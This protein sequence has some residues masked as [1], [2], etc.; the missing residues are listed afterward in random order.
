MSE[1]LAELAA[2]GEAEWD[3][4]LSAVIRWSAHGSYSAL[5]E[6]FQKTLTATVADFF[7][8]HG[9]SAYLAGKGHRRVAKER[10]YDIWEVNCVAGGF[11]LVTVPT[12]TESV[13]FDATWEE[14]VNRIAAAEQWYVNVSATIMIPEALR[15][16]C[17]P[18][19]E[20]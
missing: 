20:S 8:P 3:P 10:A 9:L 6:P 16:A 12:D 18:D 2:A 1:V 5:D 11:D 19:T 15:D 13:G 4:A 14:A 17:R 7:H